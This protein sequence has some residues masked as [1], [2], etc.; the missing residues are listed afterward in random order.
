MSYQLSTVVV[1]APGSYS[2]T[3]GQEMAMNEWIVA[4]P[5]H[6]SVDD[7]G[8]EDDLVKM[9]VG[10]PGSAA[11]AEAAGASNYGPPGSLSQSPD[12]NR[13]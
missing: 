11:A 8:S 9:P 7:T 13:Q 5:G 4:P 10:P 1:G 6:D 12:N 3:L 2:N